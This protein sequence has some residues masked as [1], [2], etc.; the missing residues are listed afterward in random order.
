[1]QNRKIKASKWL[2]Q[3]A[4]IAASGLGAAAALLTRVAWVESGVASANDPSVPLEL[5]Q[6]SALPKMIDSEK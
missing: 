6:R 1:M 3:S 4:R 2:V 5:P